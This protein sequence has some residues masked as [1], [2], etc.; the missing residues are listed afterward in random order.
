[1]RVKELRPTEVGEAQVDHR[2][3]E[4]PFLDVLQ[5]LAGRIAADDVKAVIAEAVTQPLQFGRIVF[6]HQDLG[7]SVRRHCHCS[8]ER[9][10]HGFPARRKTIP[11]RLPLFRHFV[12]T[13]LRV[14]T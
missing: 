1:M 12:E 13:G 10:R 3:A 2:H 14:G 6:H 8:W 7:N 11:Y 5:S 9:C 4:I